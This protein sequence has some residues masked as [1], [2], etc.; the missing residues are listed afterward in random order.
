MLRAN[1]HG[2]LGQIQIRPNARRSSDTGRLQNV[3]DDFPGKLTGRQMVGLQVA[4]GVDEHLIDAVWVDVLRRHM[5]EVNAVDA[6]A[7]VN[8]VGHPGWSHDIVEGQGRIS[9]HLRV[10]RGSAGELPARGIPLPLVIDLLDP[11]DHLKQP[12][13]AGNA[14]RL[15]GR[16]DR[17]TDGLFSA[18]QVRHHEVGVQWIQ[19]TLDAL[20]TCVKRF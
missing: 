12:G 19:P 13:P 9:P 15:Q 6:G 20:H 18:A 2:D 1:V 5:L 11:L 3:E 8:I 10:V 7:P 17:Q 4:G 14:I 16:C